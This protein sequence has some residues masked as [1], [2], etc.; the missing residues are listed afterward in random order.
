MGN[1]RRVSV[2]N[3]CPICKRS[4]WCTV[5]VDEAAVHC[6][7]TPSSKE[8]DA[9]GWI[10]RTGTSRTTTRRMPE[11]EP[12]RPT[13]DWNALHAKHDPAQVGVLA[14]RLGLPD[15]TLLMLDV[16]RM[17]RGGWAFPMLDSVGRIIGIRTRYSDG[18]KKAIPGS[19]SGVFYCKARQSADIVF[20][21]E[22]P[23]DTAA[24]LALG[25]AA[26][27]RPSCIGQEKI[28]A[29]TIRRWN[30]TRAIILPDNDT[31]DVSRAMVNRGVERM[32][33]AL[34]KGVDA[35]I[36]RLPAKDAREWYCSGGTREEL[37]KRC[38]F[39][40]ALPRLDESKSAGLT[41]I[42][43][44]VGGDART[45]DGVG[46]VPKLASNGHVTTKSGLCASSQPG[47]DPAC[48]CRYS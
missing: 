1:W 31:S 25:V 20:V 29:E 14:S 35:S 34:P 15:W 27:G 22:G 19:R 24:L 18:N 36:V 11:P 8:L 33:R 47:A 3:P 21:C 37:W 16:A 45:R 7:R 46:S 38:G 32:I 44:G 40:E 39:R 28:V 12:I 5:T 4:T 48:I 26:I 2:A 30:A 23:S 17:P 10:H 9:G 13:I 42:E 6:M 41:A 43:S